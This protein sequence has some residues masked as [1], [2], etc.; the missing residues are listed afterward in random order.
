MSL[1]LFYHYYTYYKL[2]VITKNINQALR[3]GYEI[4]SRARIT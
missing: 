1:K 2:G 3:H 4:P